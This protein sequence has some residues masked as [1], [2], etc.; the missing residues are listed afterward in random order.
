MENKL[1]LLLI[2]ILIPWVL[3]CQGKK[4]DEGRVFYD[5][6]NQ[7]PVFK[8]TGQGEKIEIDYY[9]A[10]DTI[11]SIDINVD[12]IGGAEGLH[13]YCDSL[14]YANFNEE[15][16]NEVN[17]R[18][19]YSILFDN[20]LRIREVHILQGPSSYKY[21]EKYDYDRL[22]KKILF[23][24]EGRWIKKEINNNWHIYVGLFHLK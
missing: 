3:Y 17:A 15:N 12:F 8:I 14:Y 24:T 5:K 6:S 11:T 20:K 7:I 1:I 13:K 21:D 16:Y 9:T 10:L 19:P 23:S 4:Q 2:G 22:I 18:V